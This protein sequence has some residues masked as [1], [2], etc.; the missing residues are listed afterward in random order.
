M[1]HIVTENQVFGGILRPY[2]DVEYAINDSTT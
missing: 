1:N 2:L